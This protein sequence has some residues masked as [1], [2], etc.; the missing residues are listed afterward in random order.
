M[1]SNYQPNF[2]RDDEHKE[3]CDTCKYRDEYI[4]KVQKYYCCEC[5]TLC[6]IYEQGLV[7]DCGQPWDDEHYDEKEYPEK[8]VKVDV[9]IKLT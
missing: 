4:E 1:E 7:C 8:W 6:H 5:K 9:L 2:D 3:P